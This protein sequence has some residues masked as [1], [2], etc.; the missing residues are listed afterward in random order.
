MILK[1]L[2]EIKKELENFIITI[3]IYS[4]VIEIEFAIE[5][6]AMLIIKTRRETTEG[7]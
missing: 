1:Y 2:P 6:C 3:K 7:I 5:K 4:Q